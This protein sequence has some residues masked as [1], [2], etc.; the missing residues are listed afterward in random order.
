MA[1]SC[2]STLMTN[3]RSS[4]RLPNYPSTYLPPRIKCGL[5]HHRSSCLCWT[6]HVTVSTV[7]NRLLVSCIG[8]AAGAVDIYGNTWVA[9]SIDRTDPAV[10]TM[11]WDRISTAGRQLVTLEPPTV[12]RKLTLS[13]EGLFNLAK[14]WLQTPW[15]WHGSVET[16]SIVIIREIIVCICWS[17]YRITKMS[18]LY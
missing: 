10:T 17:E 2:F 3:L 15:G 1:Y 14:Y 12:N 5:Q 13:V 9:P 7:V 16:C 8:K 18:N 6:V 11:G 4:R